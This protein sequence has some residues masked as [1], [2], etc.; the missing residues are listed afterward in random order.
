[1]GFMVFDDENMRSF[2]LNDF[3]VE[4]DHMLCWGGGTI[5]FTVKIKEFPRGFLYSYGDFLNKYAIYSNIS[6]LCVVEKNKDW[7]DI[8]FN[9]QERIYLLEV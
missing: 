9:F 6:K 3:K 2:R 4:F 1:M 8:H 7:Y 5:S